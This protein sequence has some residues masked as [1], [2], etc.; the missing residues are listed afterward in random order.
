MAGSNQNRAERIKEFIN[1]TGGFATSIVAIGGAIFYVV[2]SLTNQGNQIGNI[3][4]KI[5]NI[6]ENYGKMDQQIDDISELAKSDHE[7]LINLASIS[8]EEVAYNVKILD[9][10]FA[11]TEVINNEEF[12][13]ELNLDV[14]HI[15]AKDWDG[16]VTYTAEDFYN[17]PIITSYKDGDNDV[18]FYGKYNENGN[19]N[20]TCILNAYNGD[21]LVSVFEGVYSDGVL[22]SYK[23]ISDE[24]D[25][26][27]LVTDRIKQK[28]YNIGK[29]WVYSKTDD[30]VKEFNAENVKEKQILTINKFFNSINE[31]LLSYYKGNTSRGLYNDSTG[32]AYLIKY[33]DDGNVD[34][35]YVGGMEDGQP[36]DDTGNAWCISWGYAN[37]GYHYFKGKFQNNNHAKTKDFLKPMTQEEIKEKVNQDDFDYPLIGLLDIQ[38]I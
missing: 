7:L 26:T 3:N 4:E 35:L 18:Y 2:F 23:R 13:S 38:G 34:Y 31:R 14:S 20:G 16:D 6:Q 17:V 1:T 21:N 12:L 19:W 8:K 37:D 15:I 36:N 22:F 28:N 32:D 25:G 30:F 24:K 29:T 27:W 5:F 10:N 11:R 9:Y 33:K